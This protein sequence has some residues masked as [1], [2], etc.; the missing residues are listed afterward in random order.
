M[1]T[2]EVIERIIPLHPPPNSTTDC[3]RVI[4]G[5]F[6]RLFLDKE[7]FQNPI[8]REVSVLRRSLKTKIAVG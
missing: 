7:L 3:T 6:I 2:R 5:M 4:A 1:D 8:I